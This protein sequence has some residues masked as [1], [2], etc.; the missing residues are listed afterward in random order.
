MPDIRGMY[1]IHPVTGAV[2][3]W[4]E[5][6]SDPPG[7][8]RGVAQSSFP[9]VGSR[10]RA[11]YAALLKSAVPVAITSKVGV[12]IEVISLSPLSY[13]VEIG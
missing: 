8:I 10:T 11:Q 6:S 2:G 1:G 3:I 9:A 5:L 7:T 13:S 12:T 4:L